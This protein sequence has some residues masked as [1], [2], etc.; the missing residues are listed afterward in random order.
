M[1]LQQP[2]SGHGSGSRRHSHEFEPGAPA[3]HQEVDPKIFPRPLERSKSICAL[4]STWSILLAVASG[5]RFARS[6]ALSTQET[7][8][9]SQ[10]RWCIV[11]VHGCGS[12][13]VTV[14][15]IWSHGRRWLRT[16]CAHGR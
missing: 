6:V 8:S 12:V 4:R 16:R 3:T 1:S 7:L 2:D 15:G 9:R 10:N 13:T 11:E 5:E 14:S